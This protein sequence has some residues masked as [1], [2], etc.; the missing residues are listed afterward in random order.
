MVDYIP[1]VSKAPSHLEGSL[2]AIFANAVI[3]AFK[4]QHAMT[5]IKQIE[6]ALGRKT[7]DNENLKAAVDFA[8]EKSGLC[9]R[10]Y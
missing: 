10:L 8:K 4:L 5:R 6:G 1:V 3:P 7:L 9:A 2:V